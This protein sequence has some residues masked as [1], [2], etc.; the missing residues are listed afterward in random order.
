MKK[1]TK[2]R[3]LNET[4]ATAHDGETERLL[5]ENVRECVADVMEIVRAYKSTASGLSKVFE[6]TLCT[7]RRREADEAIDV[8]QQRLEVIY[9]HMYTTVLITVGD[10][11]AMWP[12]LFC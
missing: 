3:N 8:A 10:V 11:V 6:S 5:L 1:K 12:K 7:R 9:T 2:L 4:Q